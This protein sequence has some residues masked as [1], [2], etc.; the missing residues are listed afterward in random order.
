MEG[1]FRMH[2]LPSHPPDLD[3]RRAPEPHRRPPSRRIRPASGAL[4]TLRLAALTAALL[5]G[6]ALAQPLTVLVHDSFALS[7]DV[8]ERFEADTGIAVRLLQGGD[9][10]ELINRSILARAPLADVL[11]G[12]DNAL[13]A[14]AL[15]AGLFEPYRSPGLAGVPVAFD[16]D[17]SGHVTPIDVGYVVFNLDLDW[18]ERAGLAPPDDLDDLITPAYRGLT[19]VQ[20]PATSSPGL[21][22]LLTTIDR[23]GEGEGNDWLAF[24]QALRDNDLLVTDS[25]TD[26][27]YTAFSRY[28]GDRPIVLSYA[29]SPAAE[30][31]FADEELTS[32]PTA[33]LLCPRCAFRQI[34]GAAILAGSER[35]AEA[36]AF[37][38]FLLS[39]DVQADIPLTMFVYPALSS[40]PLPPAFLEFAATPAPSETATMTPERIA[41]GQQGWLERWTQVV[42]QGREADRVR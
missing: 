26:A 21:A 19:T 7:N 27:Y 14:R 2:H 39:P 41:D 35:R 16:F 24:W 31:L 10:G 11:F 15:D 5:I 30:V 6:A 34:E 8:F 25:W 37:I 4:R 38:D 18:F 3:G 33:N 20:N 12:V 28:G 29:T 13:L 22:F 23:Y 1:T 42:L 32:A 40:A 36:E 17:A 9:A